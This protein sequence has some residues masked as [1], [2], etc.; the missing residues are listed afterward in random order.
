M[1]LLLF[2]FF[3][4]FPQI[5]KSAGLGPHSGSELGAD[6]NPWTPA[7]YAG[8]MA[9]EDDEL[10]MESE[11]EL[12]PEEDVVTGFANGFRPTRVRTRFL[13]LH[14]GPCGEVP[15]A[16][17][18][19]LHSHGLSFTWK[20][21]PKSMNSPRT[22]LSEAV[23]AASGPGGRGEGAAGRGGGGGVGGR[24]S[25]GQVLHPGGRR[26]RG[27]PAARGSCRGASDSVHPW[28]G[29]RSCCAVDSTGAELAQVQF[30]DSGRCPCCAGH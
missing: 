25:A 30:L 23:V 29:G 5:K 20:L 15:T 11:S 8:S 10:G 16:T 9:L 26:S 24:G 21:Q 14:I 6:F 18:A 27:Q 3:R 7:A 19:P 4:N 12:E 28:S 22:Y 13:E 17:G 2:S 1:R